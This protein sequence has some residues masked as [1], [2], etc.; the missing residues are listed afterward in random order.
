[1]MA[2]AMNFDGGGF[3]SASLPAERSCMA[4]ADGGGDGGDPD[5]DGGDGDGNGNGGDGGQC[6]FDVF[7]NFF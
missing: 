4:T 6:K 3:L 1:M 7:F 5:E 2:R